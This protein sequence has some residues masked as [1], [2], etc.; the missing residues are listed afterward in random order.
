MNNLIFVTI[1]FAFHYNYFIFGNMVTNTDSKLKK[2]LDEHV[3]GTVLVASWL[4][5]QGFSHDLQ[6]YYRRSGWLESVGKGAYKRP[7]ESVQWQGALFAIQSRLDL[8]V[9]V[10]SLTAL[11]LQGLSHYFRLGEEPVY[12][13]SSPQ[14][15]LPAWFLQY[16][17]TASVQHIKT[18]IFPA[19]VGL[20]DFEEK[21][22]T[23]RIATPER[24]ILECL[25]MTP[26][27]IDMVECYQVF[28]GL[29]NLRPRL[30][31]ELLE[32]CN[33]VKVKRLFLYMADKAKHQWLSFIDPSKIS[34]GRG[35]RSIAKGG[36]Y[37]PQFHISVPKEL[38]AL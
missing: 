37:S 34:L 31:Q 17:W 23:I 28:E 18:S 27:K 35:D 25:Y 21:T 10:G 8:P 22:F 32:T 24:A 7:K 11:S 6:K 16:N 38:A 20:T 1:S 4:E 2:L 13:F 26:N 9:H 14:T 5:K 12:L 15:K 33:S 30:L 29:T 36:V 3:P 19:G